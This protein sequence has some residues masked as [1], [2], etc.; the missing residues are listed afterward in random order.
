MAVD[1]D[2]ITQLAESVGCTLHRHST[3]GGHL[4]LAYRTKVDTNPVQF[5]VH[6]I[7]ACGTMKETDMRRAMC[8]LEEY[9]AVDTLHHT[10]GV[11]ARQEIDEA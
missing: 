9:S 8:T 1:F 3:T 4:K 10:F 7:S 2:A 6:L 5:R 11:V